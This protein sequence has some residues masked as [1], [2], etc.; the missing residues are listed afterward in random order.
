MEIIHNYFVEITAIIGIVVWGIRLEGK[1][2]YQKEEIELMNK[3][4][5]ELNGI[6]KKLSEIAERLSYIEGCFR[7][8]R[9]R[10]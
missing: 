6:Y 2:K 5:D 3:R 1:V 10:E 4:I 8:I 9:E 7:S